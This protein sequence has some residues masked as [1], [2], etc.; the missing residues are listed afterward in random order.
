MAHSLENSPQDVDLDK[1]VF[2][3]QMH[4]LCG[5]RLGYQDL[6][7]SHIHLVRNVRG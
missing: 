1:Y 4:M 6:S 2:Q 3:L 5:V 7:Y